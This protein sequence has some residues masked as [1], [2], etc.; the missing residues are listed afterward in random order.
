MLQCDQSTFGEFNIQR[1]GATVADRVSVK[2]RRSLIGSVESCRSDFSDRPAAQ[3]YS[4]A[5]CCCCLHMAGAG[6]VGLSGIPIA[7]VTGVK[8]SK[9]PL[10]P[11]TNLALALSVVGGIIVTVLGFLLMAVVLDSVAYDSPLQGFSQFIL[12]IMFFAPPFVFVPFGAVVMISMKIFTA[13]VEND[14]PDV[15]QGVYCRSCGYDLRASLE[16]VSCP[17]C[18]AA[19]VKE[20]LLG[21]SFGLAIAWRITWISF[22]LSC[23]GTAVDTCRRPWT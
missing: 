5:C 13:S 11:K 10:H 12:I 17:E 22:L 7:W 21:Y 8:R 18:G 2:N 16:S 19:V 6:L 14:K 23:A 15:D 4:G 20:S 3:P 9:Q 1:L